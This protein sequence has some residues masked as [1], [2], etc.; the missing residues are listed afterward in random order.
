MIS[1]YLTQEIITIPLRKI[2]P[3]YIPHITK[4]FY[5]RMDNVFSYLSTF[6]LLLP[7]EKHPQDDEYVLVGKYDLYYFMISHTNLDEAPCIIEEF[8]GDT[9]QSLKILR[10]LHNKGDS[11][12]TSKQN[13][14]NKLSNQNLSLSQLTKMTG[15][16]K[17]D[18]K[19]YH[20]NPSVP[21][22]YINNHST[23][24][25]LNWIA[26]LRLDAAVKEFLYERAGLP[27]KH[28]D[29]LTDTKRKFLHRFF[30]NTK[31]FNQLSAPKQ[32]NVLTYA[33]NFERVV[34][35]CLQKKIDN[36]LN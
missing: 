17:Q 26:S 3:L 27:Q 1:T 33:M 19:E 2:K 18:L 13:I 21:Q 5:T 7:V 36:Y 16:T 22:K 29:R 15:F 12:K 10:R 23:E 32:I 9:T 6:D 35:E 14:L 28:Q 4:V 25:T 11:N 31:R 8:T 30:R 24:A 34:I 20:Y